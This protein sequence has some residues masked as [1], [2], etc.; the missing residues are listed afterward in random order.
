M[1]TSNGLFAHDRTSFAHLTVTA[2]RKDGSWSGWGSGSDIRFHGLDAGQIAA[3]AVGK[4]AH[5]AIPLDLDPGQYTVIL[6]PAA[7]A[8]LL[9][10]LIWSM[11]VRS[12][13]EALFDPRV[14][15]FSDPAE[16][17]API[18]IFGQDGL[19]QQRTVWIEN[20]VVKTM[21]C[22][23]YWAA[24]TGRQPQPSPSGIV[25]SGGPTSLGE[26]IR[27][28]RRGILVTRLWYTNMLDPRTLLL[29]GLTRD[30]NFLIED[31]RVAGPA[32][33]FRFNESLIA[34]LGNIDA[35]GP[36]ERVH[37]GDLYS[38]PIAAPPLLVKSFNFA[39]RSRGI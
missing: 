25:M 31:G 39:S 29:T 13:G 30:G 37:G 36:T 38:G 19:P 5:T 27:N 22:S 11:D 4:A 23:R 2:R 6:E 35:I 20:G 14:T 16:P 1:A 7:T 24:K 9:A 26:M 12:A 3:R 18:S 17:I 33:N 21:S 28:T 15:L 10:Y 32:R 34:L 8:E